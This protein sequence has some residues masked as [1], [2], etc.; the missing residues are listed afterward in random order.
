MKCPRCGQSI[1]GKTCPSCG[2]GVLEESLFCHRCGIKLEGITTDTPSPEEEID[3]SKRILCGDGTC[4]G[5]INEKGVCSVCGK[6]YSGE[7]P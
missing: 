5:V 3:F 2:V 7:S 1:G 4:I 6:P